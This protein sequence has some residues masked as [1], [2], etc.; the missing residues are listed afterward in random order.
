MAKIHD[1]VREAREAKGPDGKRLYSDEEIF[2]KIAATESGREALASAGENE[3]RSWLGLD[4]APQDP[5]PVTRYGKMVGGGLAQGVG[6]VLGL[7]GTVIDV[8]NDLLP[9]EYKHDSP[10]LRAIP[11][12]ESIRAGLRQMGVSDRAD[13]DPQNLGE[14]FLA[15]G[16]T[17]VG[18]SLPFLLT[19]GASLAPQ[20]LAS[21][22]GSGVGETAMNALMPGNPI[23]Q[24]GG[25]IIGGMTGQGG[26]RAVEHA[27]MKKGV[28]DELAAS[29][30]AFEDFSLALPRETAGR[31]ALRDATAKNA[32]AAH[33][34]LTQQIGLSTGA[35]EAGPKAVIEGTAA[36]LDPKVQSWQEAG[37]AL[38]ARARTWYETELPSQL[39]D[40]WKGVDEAVPG[41]TPVT[42]AGFEGV[43]NKITKR[44]GVAQP[45]VDLLT[46]GLPRQ[47]KNVFEKIVEGQDLGIGDFTWD[48][49][50][51]L[52]SAIGE[53]MH[54]PR[55]MPTI[56]DTNLKALYAGLTQDLG[57]TA[58]LAGV[59]KEFDAANAASKAIF[60]V[61][62]GPVARV[63]DESVSAGE[64]AKRV[65]TRSST[66]A[67]ELEALRLVAPEGVNALASATLRGTVAKDVKEA[68]KWATLPPRA[69]E[70]LVPDAA[71]RQALDDAVVGLDDVKAGMVAERLAAKKLR[72][73]TR[74]AAK[75]DF[76]AWK[77]SRD[78]AK[79]ALAQRAETA[80]RKA[81]ELENADGSMPQ[82][83]KQLRN[84]AVGGTVG[85][86]GLDLMGID[87]DQ[88]ANSKLGAAVTL[89][90][91]LLTH[92][93]G[94][95]WK[96]PELLG[97][98]VIG[99]SAGNALMREDDRR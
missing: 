13:A 90:V 55:I 72:D 75:E 21:G 19:G 26:V 85:G 37:E 95:V 33:E 93:A 15:G 29:T 92:G 96:N 68:A 40:A 9:A 25:A 78:E 20:L 34:A 2:A 62:E 83:I 41:D 61:A 67:S 16:A 65:A 53:A 64:M 36:A 42:L 47:L 44:A 86:Y 70:V 7:P 73:A 54:D 89:G 76:S 50:R 11:T 38:R 31:E 98:P 59:G 3:F 49:V 24:I 80:K 12:G 10:I 43:L 35:R 79:V 84:I 22:L 27:L 57:Q 56:G 69:K 1:Q 46:P 99:V 82:T 18:S 74:E 71:A 39:E 45:L 5:N 8:V 60:S 32:D 91:P 52:R 66:D 51:R 48:D 17:G 58:K 6:E 28:L 94:R 87:P 77:V 30:K 88:L 81:A 63:L 23:A 97:G 4:S 14:E